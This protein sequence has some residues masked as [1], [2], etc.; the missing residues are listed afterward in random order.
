MLRTKQN[1]LLLII[2]LL[3]TSSLAQSQASIDNMLP[4]LAEE[5]LCSSQ[6]GEEDNCVN[7][8]DGS[9][10][11][12]STYDTIQSNMVFASNVPA[13]AFIAQDSEISDQIIANQG[14]EIDLSN[15]NM[16]GLNIVDDESN[17]DYVLSFYHPI[18]Y[19]NNDYY[20]FQID[21]G[22][23]SWLVKIEV[24]FDEIVATDLI[25]LTEY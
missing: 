18:S 23:I 19:N 25:Q 15:A 5:Q 9:V 14:R 10:Y 22:S 6:M 7:I 8:T 3:F 1:S 13:F 20:I 2:A 17:A 24:N 12:K 11:L 4:L 21:E 16:S